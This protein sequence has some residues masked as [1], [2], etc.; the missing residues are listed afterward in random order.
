MIKEA[1]ASAPFYVAK[2]DFCCIEPMILGMEDPDPILVSGLVGEREKIYD[3]ARANRNIYNHLPKMIKGSVRYA[4][5]SSVDQSP[6]DPDVTIFTANVRQAQTLLRSIGYSNGDPWSCRCTPV[7]ACAWLYVYPVITGQANFTI[8]GLSC[9]M[10]Q[11]KVL[12]EGLFLIAIPFNMMPMVVENLQNMRWGYEGIENSR[13]VNWEKNM[14]FFQELRK[15]L[16]ST[17]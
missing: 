9:G 3:E 11:L 12:P 14:V 17:K 5:F 4:A 8:T 13:D 16:E 1:Q 2:E 7:A 6:F 15:E 10:Q